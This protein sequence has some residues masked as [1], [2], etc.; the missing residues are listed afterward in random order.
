LRGRRF[1]VG[2]FARSP[3]F[4]RDGRSAR[5]CSFRRDRSSCRRGG[6]LGLLR[7]KRGLAFH[8]GI[9]EFADDN[10]D[11]ADTVVI[12]GDGKVDGIRV[13]VRIDEGVLP[14]LGGAAADCG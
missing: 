2:G 1:L 8:N 11:G 9:G 10:L 7:R 12:A 6:G 5:R 3:R 4:G 13:A 14:V